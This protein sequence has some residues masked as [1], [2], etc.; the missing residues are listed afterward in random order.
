[1]S[2][3]AVISVVDDGDDD[4]V[5]IRRAFQQAALPNPIQV[6]RNGEEALAYLGG[7]GKFSNRVEYPLPHLVLLDLNMPRVDG[8]EV[9]TWIRQEPGMRGMV[10]IVLTSSDRIRDVNRAYEIGANSFFVKDL[11]FKN[12]IEFCKLVQSY[13]LKVAR[14]PESTRSGGELNLLLSPD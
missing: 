9:L 7:A 10:V 1:M 4:V 11:D 12:F 8:F 5:L 3:Q 6:V 14:L 13:W 2:E